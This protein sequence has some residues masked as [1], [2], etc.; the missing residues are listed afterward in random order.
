MHPHYTTSDSS[1]HPRTIRILRRAGAII[2]EAAVAGITIALLLELA[3]RL[4]PALIPLPLLVNF[5]KHLRGEIAARVHLP[6]EANALDVGRDDGG[7]RLLSYK[8]NATVARPVDGAD[9]R[10]GAVAS[11]TLDE[12]GFCNPPGAAGRIDIVAIGDS[13][14]W[15]TRVAPEDTWTALASER[16]GYRIYSL[17]LGG[18][19]PYGYLQILKRLG[20]DMS[21]RAVIMNIYEGNDFQGALEYRQ[22]LT[23]REREQG[24]G[25]ERPLGACMALPTTLC[26]IYRTLKEGWLGRSS[27]VFNAAANALREAVARARE[28][29]RPSRRFA[30]VTAQGEVEFNAAQA[31][32]W[33]GAEKLRAGEADLSVFDDALEEF[34]ILSRRHGFLPIVTYAPAA[35]SAYRKRIHFE[36]PAVEELANWFSEAQRAYF[37]AKAGEL[38]YAFIDYT[39]SL[40]QAA[41]GDALLYFPVNLHLTRAGHQAVAGA[42]QDFLVQQNILPPQQQR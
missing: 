11:V 27:Y 41:A 6:L 13:F 40:R 42:L 16:S 22:Y 23:Q 10:F 9:E 34:V 21:P 31:S 39:P 30:V 7:L 15:C 37:R 32:D 28:A 35:F 26:R 24:G 8:P 17:G 12:F 38:G 19:E 3:L 1:S 18:T 5:E 2:G 14:T 20:L 36:D 4:F 29:E 33:D 25:L